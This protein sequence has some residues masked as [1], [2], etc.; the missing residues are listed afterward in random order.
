[1]RIWV[2]GAVAAG[3]AGSAAIAQQGARLPNECRQQ[4]MALCQSR[5]GGGIRECVRSVLPQLSDTCR[6]AVSDRAAAG[7][8]LPPGMREAA[9]GRDAKQTLDYT[10]PAGSAK[11]PILLFVHGGGWA[12]GDKRHSAA[13]K[14]THFT[15]TGWAFASANYRL[16]PAATVEQQAADVAAAIAWLRANAAAFG[17]DPDRIVLMGHSAGAH[18]A[19][20]VATDPAYLAAAKVPLAAIAGVVLLDGAGYDV[21][22]QIASPRNVVAGMYNAA[23]GAD[24]AR[25]AKLSPT[26]QAAP[27]NASAWLILPVATRGDSNAQSRGLAAALTRA[28]ARA[29]VVPV[30]D[31]THG[32][33]NRNLG[34]AGDVATAEV[35][36]FLAGLRR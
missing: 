14:A 36:R 6:K 18:L 8:A 32:Q 10:R 19:A 22:T 26:V 25:H 29:A 34:N 28:G 3:V 1:M 7:Q 5:M 15:A 30:P 27:P 16:V 23:F 33:L 13:L 24:P 20:L 11:A 31:T 4:I 12:I 35:D 21:A 2:L 17:F 9:Y